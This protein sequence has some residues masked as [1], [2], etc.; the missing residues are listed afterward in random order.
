MTINTQT[1]TRHAYL[2]PTIERIGGIADMT[3]T[4][5]HTSLK[6]DGAG[7]YFIFQNQCLDWEIY[8]NCESPSP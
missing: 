8:S 4:G 6:S 7:D 3:R 5:G 2:P 1:G